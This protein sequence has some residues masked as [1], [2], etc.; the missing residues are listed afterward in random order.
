MGTG[1]TS[2]D[3]AKKLVITYYVDS[4]GPPPGPAGPFAADD[5][6]PACHP[7][8]CSPPQRGRLLGIA[9]PGKQSGSMFSATNGPAG[10]GAF[11]LRTG[12]TALDESPLSWDR[13]F[14][15][16]SW[17]IPKNAEPRPIPKKLLHFFKISFTM[18]TENGDHTKPS[19]GRGR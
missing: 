19:F 14:F 17:A 12:R 7:R 2:S 11:L 15:R 18:I 4:A 5:R 6:P 3:P 13:V 16:E 10:P 1:T 9:A 8:R